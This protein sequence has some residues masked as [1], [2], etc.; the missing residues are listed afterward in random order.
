MATSSKR[1][2]RLVDA[3]AFPGFRPH[4]TVRGIFGDPKA[5]VVDLVR[6]SKKLLVAAVGEFTA[7]G[8]TDVPDA[9]AICPRAI[10]ACTWNSRFGVFSARAAVR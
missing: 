10:G 6:R 2:R 9:L 5:C 3:Y 1:K 7:A 8:T 4:P